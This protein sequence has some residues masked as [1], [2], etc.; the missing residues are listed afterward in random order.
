MCNKRL[1]YF[2][3]FYQLLSI[4][5]SKVLKSFTLLHSFSNVFGKVL[6]IKVFNKIFI[7]LRLFHYSSIPFVFFH[8][9]MLAAAQI[10]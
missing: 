10:I 1:D 4:K 3:R 6:G 5:T 9:I 2:D 7:V 8:Q